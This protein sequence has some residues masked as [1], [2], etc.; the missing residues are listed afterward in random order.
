[1]TAP[2]P[3]RAGGDSLRPLSETLQDL[4]CSDWQLLEPDTG[5]VS[6]GVDHRRGNIIEGRLPD[7]LRSERA[8]PLPARCEEDLDLLW[9]LHGGEKL[10]VQKVSVRGV[11][12]IVEAYV[13]HESET[14]PL[15]EP[16]VKLPLDPHRA[17][18]L[19]Y[20]RPTNRPDHPHLTCL[21]VHLHLDELDGEV[22]RKARG[23]I[24]GLA[25]HFTVK[26]IEEEV[27]T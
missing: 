1:M 27:N 8:C 24:A 17:Y 15:C 2:R 11:P 10:V 19:T 9:N 14:D 4:L 16:A 18:R 5:G 6:Y 13:L 7:S 12:R 3:T 21:R 20:I 23:R 26:F 25:L 22:W